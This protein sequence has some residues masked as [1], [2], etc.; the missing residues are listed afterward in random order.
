[1]RSRHSIH[2]IVAGALLLGSAAL[3]SAQSIESGTVVRI[4]PHSSV[5]MLEDGRMYRVTPSTLLVVDNRPVPL[6]TLRPG[7]RVV[8]QS[9]EVVTLRD[10]QYVAVTPPPAAVAQAPATVVTPA[11]PAPATVVTPAPPVVAQAPTTAVPVGARQT[12]HGYVEEVEPNG[13]VT[14]RTEGDT[15]ELK[16]NRTAMQ[17]V[18]KGDTVT[19]DLTFSAPGAPAALPR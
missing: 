6:T 13:E 11:P 18:K 19:L 5:V 9:G 16:L 2:G 4:D 7:H 3:A 12:I 8:I 10:G 17:H 14:I 15:F 1:M